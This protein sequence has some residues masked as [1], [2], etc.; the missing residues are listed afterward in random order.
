MNMCYHLVEQFLHF[1]M[2]LCSMDYSFDR[3]ILNN[4]VGMCK[5]KHYLLELVYQHFDKD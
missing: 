5:Y 4:L 2:D 3:M 1:D